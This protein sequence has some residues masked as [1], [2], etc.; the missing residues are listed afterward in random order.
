MIRTSV[1]RRRALS[2][3]LVASLQ[4]LLHYSRET[5]FRSSAPRGLFREGT[6]DDLRIKWVSE[7]I[8]SLRYRTFRGTAE[9]QERKTASC[10]ARGNRCGA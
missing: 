3:A 1:P 8:G 9:A 4:D 10:S 6:A 7:L 2:K 5:R